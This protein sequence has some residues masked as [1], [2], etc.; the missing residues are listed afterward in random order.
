[1]F[2]INKINNIINMLNKD[3]RKIE[4]KE[5]LLSLESEILAYLKEINFNPQNI[6]SVPL[7]EFTSSDILENNLN[8]IKE[9]PTL[10]L[11]EG[12]EKYREIMQQFLTIYHIGFLSEFN[13]KPSGMIEV[14]I[15][16]LISKPSFS[17]T[18]CSDKINFEE[19]LA[20]LE[21]EDIMLKKGKRNQVI[22]PASNIDAIKLLLEKIEAKHIKIEVRQESELI[23]DK[24]SFIVNPKSLDSFNEKK[25][26]FI[27]PVSDK[28]NVDEIENI[29]KL[30]KDMAYAAQN[31]K[32]ESLK[33]VCGSL[34][35]SYFSNICDIL[36]IET[37]IQQAQKERYK[38]DKEENIKKK[39]LKSEIAK[40]VSAENLAEIAKAVNKNLDTFLNSNIDFHISKFSVSSYETIK[41]SIM[42]IMSYWMD[43]DILMTEEDYKKLFKTYK[44]A[45][46]VDYLLVPLFCDEN[47]EKI[48]EIIKDK[49][50]DAI[51]ESFKANRKKE[52]YTDNYFY[53]ISEIEFTF[54]SFSK[55]L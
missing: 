27:F 44:N 14:I 1:M 15:P 42:P 10:G 20:T 22:I 31:A 36:S 5:N 51:F 25:E 46:R 11:F 17:A 6:K 18:P 55:F 8:Q 3:Y 24:I 9:N 33:D 12:I 4:Y 37:K 49:I 19:Q 40:F 52:D 50:P 47:I 21:K 30:L 38:R 39:E 41:V 53:Y 35:K 45:N 28:L 48:K 29:Y 26:S 2:D 43:D 32:E 23:I 54:S 7:K 34:L 16:A 13:L